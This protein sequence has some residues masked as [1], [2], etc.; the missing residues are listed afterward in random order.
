MIAKAVLVLILILGWYD[1]CR[2][3]VKYFKLKNIDKRPFSLSRLL[4]A[5]EGFNP[6]EQLIL[7]IFIIGLGC[8]VVYLY[9]SDLK[10]LFCRLI[11]SVE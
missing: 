3:V 9:A 6:L 1:G 7:G 11:S 2:R 4:T 10:P 5:A 8:L